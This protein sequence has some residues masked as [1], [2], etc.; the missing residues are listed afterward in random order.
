MRHTI[1]VVDDDH[2]LRDVLLRGLR[3][4]GF[5]AVGARDGAGALRLAGDAV[6]AVVLDVGLPDADGRDVCQAMRANGFRAPVLFLT[7][8]HRLT[9]RLGGFSA[10]GDDYLTKPFHLVELAARLRAAIKRAGREAPA[11]TGDLSLDPARFTAGVAGRDTA[12]TPTEFRLLAT[13]M[14]AR[15]DIVGRRE[16]VRAGWPEGARVSDNTLDQYLSRLRRKLREAGSDL[17]IRTTRGIGH[18]L[19]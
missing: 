6:D 13:L 16:L 17:T 10:G 8:H 2:A 15:G 4:E 3:D 5:T 19:V 7:A 12:L 9:D 14:A 11:R 1:L 18:R